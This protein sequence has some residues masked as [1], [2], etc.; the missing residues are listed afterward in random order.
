MLLLLSSPGGTEIIIIAVI[1]FIAGIFITRYIFRI[2]A[3]V[4]NLK[5]QTYLLVRMAKQANVPNEEI[6]K[7][8]HTVYS[9]ISDLPINDPKK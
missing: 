9:D 8:L 5:L 4:D 1:G 7:I 6:E 3:I 2:D